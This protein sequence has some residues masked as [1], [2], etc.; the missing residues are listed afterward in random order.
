MMKKGEKEMKHHSK[1]ERKE[2]PSRD[3]KMHEPTQR[4]TKHRLDRKEAPSRD[5][6]M[7]EPKTGMKHSE[8]KSKHRREY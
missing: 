5:K 4:E 7:H 3:K 2:V 8:E 1:S 6:K